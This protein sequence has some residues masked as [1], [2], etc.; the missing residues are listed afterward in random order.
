MNKSNLS[1]QIR[2]ERKRKGLTQAELAD[3]IGFSEM[4]VRR[5][6][7]GERSPRME[8]VEKLADVLGTSFE[9]RLNG[10]EEKKTSLEQLLQGLVDDFRHSSLPRDINK[11]EKIKDPLLGTYR[12]YEPDKFPE[13]GV[14][15]W[16]SV[17]DNAKNIAKSGTTQEKE[18]AFMML[19]MAVNALQKEEHTSKSTGETARNI[20]V[21]Q[22]NFNGDNNYNGDI[23]KAATA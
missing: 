16:G 1:E 18:I 13:L 19:N 23:P 3:K 17:V 20:G 6:E 22:N 8:E 14:A 4:T 5:W 9:Y 15:Y 21:Q 2:I 10:K 7:S 12:V 11:E